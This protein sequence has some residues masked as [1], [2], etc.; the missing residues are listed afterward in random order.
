MF[1]S[2][3]LLSL[4][5]LFVT[6]GAKAAMIPPYFNVT[7]VNNSV[8]GDAVFNFTVVAPYPYNSYGGPFSIQTQNGMG[9]YDIYA[10]SGNGTPFSITEDV[11]GGWKKPE[12]SC[13]SDNPQVTTSAIANGV[14]ITAYP[15]S[16]ITCTFIN[17]KEV[18]KTPVL[19]VPGI[20]GTEMKDS[21]TL[22]WVDL[23]KM[24]T[25]VGD[26]F[27]DT[28]ALNKDFTPIDSSV[29][30]T[31]IIRVEGV[32]LY[33]FDYTDGLINTFIGQGYTEG[34]DLFTFPYDWRYGV[35]GGNEAA[36]QQRIHDIIAANGATK[37]DVIAHSTGGLL[38][39]KY[40]MDHPADHHI[41]KAIFVGVPNMGAPKAVKVLISGDSFGIPFLADSEIKKIAANMPVSYDLLPS[42]AYF[43][44]NGSFIRT[45]SRNAPSP[46]SVNDLNYV[47]SADFLISSHDLNAAALSSAQSLHTADFDSF[48]LRAAGV[49]FYNVV[50]C[51]TGTMG[52]FIENQTNELAMDGEQY[53]PVLVSGDGTV[54]LGSASAVP[55]NADHVVYIKGG[56]H[57]N[58]LSGNGARQVI[59]NLST[60]A[61]LATTSAVVSGS[62]M[63]NDLADCALSGTWWQIFSPL[64]LTVTD[65]QG[66]VAGI[67][68]DGSVENNIP[69]V[70]YEVWGDH[71]FVYVPTDEGQAYHAAFAG[72]ATGTFTLK[73]SEISHGALVGTAVW[74][75]VP[76]TSDLRGSLVADGGGTPSLLLDTDGDGAIE[77]SVS[78]ADSLDGAQ[79]ADMLA[80]TTRAAFSGT[81][82]K[83]GFYRSDVDVTLAADDAVVSGR[84]M[85]PSGVAKGMYQLDGDAGREGGGTGAA[86]AAGAAPCAFSVTAEGPHAL[87]FYSEDR[88]A[89]AELPQTISFTIDKT[90]PEFSIKFS[91]AAQDVIFSGTDN[92][93][94]P[95]EVSVADEGGDISLADE[96]GNRTTLRLK[97]KDRKTALRAEIESLAYNGTKADVSKN[98][99]QF[100]WKR[101]RQGNLSSLS[102]HVQSK[103]GFNVTAT[104]E[105]GVTVISGR[106]AAGKISKTLPGLVMITVATKKGEL[107]WQ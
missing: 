64:A 37:V 59:V 24:A 26:S 62:D 53:V 77:E 30:P 69:G 34:K 49:D 21:N 68:A 101:D 65:A 73:Q 9:S 45:L 89:N 51:K 70:D 90:P 33:R 58:L 79:S 8:G 36:L 14:Q 3:G 91:E 47:Q 57:S 13:S 7:V 105:R 19:I 85:E 80:P 38:V 23:L 103:D 94:T 106:D 76:V 95:E 67:A 74:S 5:Y 18:A 107:T 22:L 96:A 87:S 41:G 16:S 44:R 66:N 97:E 78:P 93:S 61:G 42:Q 29:L 39:K 28:L 12:V 82:G 83:P 35:S 32:P 27:M 25:D 55:A 81:A 11:S 84:E 15:Y 2:I 43:D 75:D 99:L 50:G 72:T 17:S 4:M 88:A 48:D 102:Q 52:Q 56:E 31:D 63:G 10:V 60:G 92:L 71:K 6:V 54:P 104:Y 20:L 98:K 46:P 40:V 1:L 100:A 86:P